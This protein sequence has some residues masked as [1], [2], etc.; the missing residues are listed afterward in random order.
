[1]ALWLSQSIESKQNSADCWLCTVHCALCTVLTADCWIQLSEK[2]LQLLV[3]QSKIPAGNVT[4]GPPGP[5][6]FF[7]AAR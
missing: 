4:P 5:V 7:D 1:V 2:P 3:Q 6:R